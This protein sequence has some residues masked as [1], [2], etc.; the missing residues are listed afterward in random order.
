MNSA[1]AGHR[2]AAAPPDPTPGEPLFRPFDTAEEYADAVEDFLAG[3]SPSVPVLV[4]SRHDLRDGLAAA[5]DL[6]VGLRRPDPLTTGVLLGADQLPPGLV[7]LVRP[8]ATTWRTLAD[9]DQE[10]PRRDAGELLVVGTYDHLRLDPVR[11]LLLASYRC[12]TG[13]PSFLSGRDA[14]SLSWHLAKQFA[15]PNRAVSSVGVFTDT[16]RPPRTGEV[17]V[18]DDRDFERRDIQA[19]ILDRPWRRVVFQGHGKDDSINLGLFTICGLNPAVAPTPDLLRPRCGYGLSC[20]KPEDKLVP[21]RQVRAVEV[22]LSACN[23]GPLADLALYDPRYQLLL[24]ALD[25]PARTVVSAVSVH[26][27]DRP[28][29]VAWARAAVEGA[30]STDVLNASL[31]ASHPYPAFMRFGMPEPDRPP[32]PAPAEHAPDPLVL[33]VG[34]RVTALLTGDL[35]PPRHA[36]RPRLVKLARKV[37]GWVARPTHAADQDPEEIRASLEA[38]LQSLD[39]VIARQVAGNPEDEIMNFPAH[40]GDRSRLAAEATEAVTCHCGRPAQR[41]LR[42]GLLP[43]VLD[44]TCVV[45]MRCGDVVFQVPES[46]ELWADAA[47]EAPSGGELTVT[48]RVRGSRRGPAQLGLFVPTYLREACAV[49]PV[50]TRV[51]LS[52]DEEREVPFTLRFVEDTSPQ[53]YYFTAY[54]VQDLAITTTRRHFGVV[55]A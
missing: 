15:T 21:L 49:E 23:S 1:V 10:I 26:D 8:L 25:S 46:P 3:T 6:Y 34:R 2:R 55:P 22:V 39:H 48:L 44:T 18:F 29:N 37:D 11:D 42:R 24:N 32:V 31:A 50:T 20:Y 30:D 38:D 27:S 47:D 43:Y 51:R 35:L 5:T 52:P 9:L 33:T 13:G 54:V 45:C 40:F 4:A 14:A 41:F 19:E 28:E 16:D 12:P 36:L 7:A 53:A 17:L